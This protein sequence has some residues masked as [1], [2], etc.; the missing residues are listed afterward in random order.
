MQTAEGEGFDFISAG[1]HVLGAH[2]DRNPDRPMFTHD[3]PFHEPFGLFSFA[4]AVTERIEFLTAI[5]ILPQR[6]TA[7]VAKQAAELA[8][9]SNNRFLMGIGVGWNIPEFETLNVPFENRGSRAEEQFAVMRRLWSEELV[10]FVGRFHHLDRVAIT[11]RPTRNVPILIGCAAEDRLLRRVAR[12]ADGWIPQ[13]DAVESLPRLFGMLD[14]VGRSRTDFRVVS[15]ITVGDDS[16]ALVAEAK[17]LE[18]LG[19]THCTVRPTAAHGEPPL[20]TLRKA[21]TAR[22]VIAEG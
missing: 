10:S 19:V 21:A 1:E 22:K 7:L 12:I 2:A 5:L 16:A 18:A 13:G 14:E 9:L 4:A 17:R 20:E 8:I 6:Q 15:G 11:P 3:R